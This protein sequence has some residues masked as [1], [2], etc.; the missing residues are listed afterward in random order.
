MSNDIN[1]NIPH[2]LT[3]TNIHTQTHLLDLQSANLSLV[4]GNPFFFLT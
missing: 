3:D 2:T 4:I 1:L